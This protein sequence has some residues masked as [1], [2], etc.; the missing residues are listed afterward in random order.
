MSNGNSVISSLVYKFSER[1]IVKLI[2]FVISIVLARLI[3]PAT[4]GLLAILT[5]F[6]NL[7]QV[8]VQGGLNV[9]LIQNKETRRED[10]STVF[11]ISLV[12]AFVIYITLFACAPLIANYYDR[13]ELI[14]PLRVLSLSMIFGAFNSVQMAKLS[15]EMQFRKQMICNLV[16]TVIAGIVGIAM[17]YKSLGLWA[18]VTYNLLS[19]VVVCFVMLTVA[20][21][22]PSLTF[23]FQ[24]AKIFVG[25]GWKILVSNLMYSLYA[26]IR[27][28]IIGKVYTADD[29][30]LY[31]RANQL[32]NIVSYNLETAV[33]S[34]MLPALSKN[35]SDLK[36]I[37]SDLSRMI[38]AITFVITPMMI[39]IAAI[40][41]P[42]VLVV[43]SDKWA[44]CIPYMMIFSIGYIFMPIAGSCNVAIKAIGRSDVFAKNQAIRIA[45][46]FLI[47]LVS[48]FAF[49]NVTAIVAGYAI[50]LFLETLIAIWPA[51][52]YI[53]YTYMDALKDVAPNLLVS[54]A[55]G[56]IVYLICQVVHNMLIALVVGTATGTIVFFLLAY[57]VKLPVLQEATKLLNVYKHRSK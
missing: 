12:I 54:I 53:G 25:Y 39:G 55:M 7:S 49:H 27:S 14:S 30:A 9:A 4:F 44:A 13:Q 42:F 43:L 50:S 22:F 45:T 11:W 48:L 3:E 31:D 16:S 38:R 46:M 41:K 35:Q 57:L 17:A 21:W 2:A 51:S 6:I 40:A 37:K 32:P 20:N 10:Y 18:L 47:L 24:R 29:L 8:F 1:V 23:S 34:V 26:D 19:Q 56:I 33:Q 15:R 28:L 5:V 52:K 36:H